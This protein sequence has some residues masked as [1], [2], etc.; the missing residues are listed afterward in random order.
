LSREAENNKTITDQRRRFEMSTDETDPLPCSG[1]Q[2]G[3]R[4]VFVA[5]AIPVA[6]RISYFEVLSSQSLLRNL[7]QR[8]SKIQSDA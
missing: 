3:T 1:R 4:M 7:E 6:S 2:C 5:I 8:T